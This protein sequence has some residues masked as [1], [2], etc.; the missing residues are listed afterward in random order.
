MIHFIITGPSMNLRG[1]GPVTP[2]GAG[3][4]ESVTQSGWLPGTPNG[5]CAGC[6]L[7]LLPTFGHSTPV[8][9]GSFL[10]GVNDY[11]ST[12]FTATP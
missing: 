2:A 11:G 8:K 1:N 7:L 4:H 6:F 9:P 3:R 5:G 12:I 10:W